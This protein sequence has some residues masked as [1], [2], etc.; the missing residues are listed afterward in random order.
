MSFQVKHV[1]LGPNSGFVD[2]EL[3]FHS[4]RKMPYVPTCRVM[5]VANPF[6][7]SISMIHFPLKLPSFWSCKFWSRRSQICFIIICFFVNFGWHN[8]LSYIFFSGNDNEDCWSIFVV[9]LSF[10]SITWS[11]FVMATPL[12]IHQRKNQRSQLMCR[13]KKK[14]HLFS[15]TLR[16]RETAGSL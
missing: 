3:N 2:G 14:A 6:S 8:S 15:G 1:V 10:I 7:L 12:L 11:I 13:A 5:W 4:K 9:P 16:E